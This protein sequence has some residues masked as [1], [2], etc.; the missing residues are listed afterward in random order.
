[1]DWELIASS[2]VAA[3]VVSAAVN[4]AFGWAR[5]V[6][7]ARDRRNETRRAHLRE[8]VVE[9]LAAEERRFEEDYEVQANGADLLRHLERKRQTA[10]DE[11]WWSM[12]RA[13]SER[14]Q[15]A[16]REGANAIGRMRLYS[17][18]V[19]RHAEAVYSIRSTIGNPSHL[20]EETEAAHD[21]ALKMFVKAARREL[22][23]D[24]L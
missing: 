15:A 8:A 3:G 1:M 4:A 23:I 13:T 17:E 19:Y 20:N 18:D 22:G 2:A 21:N 24:D 5:F 6:A 16:L 10:E 7:E 12:Y 9:F 14:W 11:K